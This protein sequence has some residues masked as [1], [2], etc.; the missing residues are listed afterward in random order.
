M[1]TSH[2]LKGIPAA[3]E[4]VIVL[5]PLCDKKWLN[6]KINNYGKDVLLKSVARRA[7][8][9]LLGKLV[10]I[11]HIGTFPKEVVWEGASPAW[12]TDFQVI[13]TKPKGEIQVVPK[14]TVICKL[15]NR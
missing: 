13:S 11:D 14:T 1:T 2:R 7:K 8:E 10:A 12:D 9:F 6:R 4:V 5:N 15:E 3:V